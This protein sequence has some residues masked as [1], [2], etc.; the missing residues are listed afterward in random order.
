[1]SCAV[2]QEPFAWLWFFLRGLAFRVILL[3]LGACILAGAVQ[4]VRRD[5]IPWVGD[6]A[7]YIEAQAREENL[8]LVDREVVRGMIRSGSHLILDARPAADY[9]AGHIESALSMPSD[10]PGAHLEVLSILAPSDALMIYCSGYECD[11]SIVLARTLRAQGF[12]NLVL[13]AGGWAEWSGL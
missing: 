12:T 3:L 10:D 11:D 13:Y 7:H 5:T 8:L 2:I 9:Q 1:M 4:L 6:W